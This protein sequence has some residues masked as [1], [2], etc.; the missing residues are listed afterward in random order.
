MYSKLFEGRLHTEPIEVDLQKDPDLVNAMELLQWAYEGWLN[1]EDR[2][3]S[4]TLPQPIE[5]PEKGDLRFAAD[6]LSLCGVAVLLHHEIAHDY[7]NHSGCDLEQERDADQVAT[8]FIVG[9]IDRASQRAFFEKRL[10]GIA[11]A[12]AVLVA[13]SIHTEY[14]G[15]DTHPRTFDRLFNTLDRLTEGAND[16][17]WAICVCIVKLHLDNV[18]ITTPSVAYDSFRQCLDA[19]VELLSRR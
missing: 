17:A 7:L 1:K 19:Y 10:L 18:G 3:W 15:G 12:Y 4:A 8:E 5:S 11:L 14:F 2:P 13:Q 6:E 9:A 16:R